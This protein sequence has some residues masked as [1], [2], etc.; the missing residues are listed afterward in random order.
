[1][2]AESSP[3]LTSFLM[4]IL[5]WGTRKP[6][7][8]PTKPPIEPTSVWAMAIVENT[9]QASSVRK[10]QTRRIHFSSLNP[11]LSLAQDLARPNYDNQG[12]AQATLRQNRVSFVDYTRL[13]R[14]KA[15]AFCLFPP[16]QGAV[17]RDYK[18]VL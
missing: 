3:P 12:Q 11:A 18:R 17:L 6:E 2:V 16:P 15:D 8:S 14:P 4:T 1:V 5:V 9:A 13:K 7:A 10:T